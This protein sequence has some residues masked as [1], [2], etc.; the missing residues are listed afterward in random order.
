MRPTQG[1]PYKSAIFTKQDMLV[2]PQDHIRPNQGLHTSTHTTPRPAHYCICQALPTL[3]QG[4]GGEYGLI[5]LYPGKYSRVIVLTHLLSQTTKP[6]ACSSTCGK[7]WGGTWFQPSPVLEGK[8]LNILQ[9][10]QSLFGLQRN[11]KNR[12]PSGHLIGSEPEGMTGSSCT[13]L[14][15]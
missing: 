2:Q 4:S 12:I 9:L 14:D 13:M 5:K 3:R 7:I 10:S 6:A 1:G 11:A 8:T 15:T